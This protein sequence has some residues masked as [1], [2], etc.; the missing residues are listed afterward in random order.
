MAD[1]FCPVHEEY[2]QSIAVLNNNIQWLTK[3]G[4][5]VAATLVTAS[6]FVLGAIGTFMY[7]AND[8]YAQIQT[9]TKAIELI[10]KYSDVGK[11]MQ[12]EVLLPHQSGG[13]NYGE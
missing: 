2:I 11:E 9:N 5:W 8:A 13:Y 1:K 7:K 10:I 6:L 12:K 3:I 4:R